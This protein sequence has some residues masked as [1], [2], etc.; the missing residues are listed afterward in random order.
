MQISHAQMEQLIE[1]YMIYV[2]KIINHTYYCMDV[3]TKD[4]LHQ[5]GLIGL[6]RGITDYYKK[7][8][9]CFI[10]KEFIDTICAYIRYEM[11]DLFKQLNGIKISA[12][13]WRNYV[14]VQKII[15]ENMDC[16]AQR[17]QTQ[18]S[19]EGL[20]YDWYIKTANAVHIASLD[21]E[22][23]RENQYIHGKDH[24]L[25]RFF[26]QTYIDYIINSAFVGIKLRRDRQ[27]IKSWLGSI[28]DGQE[29]TQTQLASQYRISPSMV[30]V[31]LNRFIDICRFV[32]DCE[33]AFHDDPNGT[34]HFPQ[35]KMPNILKKEKKIPGVR[36]AIQNNKWKVEITIGKRGSIFIGYFQQYQDAVCARRDAEI[37]YRGKSDIML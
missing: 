26:D 37:K 1:D 21:A 10:Q 20:N 23:G 3:N 11:A 35:V 30:R 17:L 32:R 6:W 31:I 5:V 9:A 34:I 29:L 4:E 24:N 7:D 28:C 15:N 33:A 27:L 12:N 22:I 2:D 14:Q 25:D 16:L 19:V 8:P 36:W 18:I 13:Q